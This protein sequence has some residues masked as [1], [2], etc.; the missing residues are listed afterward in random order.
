MLSEIMTIGG[1]T[2]H[3]HCIITIKK[4]KRKSKIKCNSHNQNFSILMK[5]LPSLF[6]KGTASTAK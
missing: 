3:P 6:V 1:E 2:N 5:F 4:K